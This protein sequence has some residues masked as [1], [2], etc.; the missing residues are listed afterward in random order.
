MKTAQRLLAASASLALFSTSVPSIAIAAN[1]NNPLYIQ[2]SQR[3]C[4]RLAGREKM[5]CLATQERGERLRLY[6]PTSTATQNAS[7]IRARRQIQ[8]NISSRNLR[9]RGATPNA[10]LLSKNLRENVRTRRQVREALRDARLGC[11]SIDDSTE[12]ALCYRKALSE[13]Q[14]SNFQ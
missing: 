6:L 8:A 14:Q 2:A 1:T 5:R 10:R 4:E 7:T 9:A 12:K 11:R 13:A 3:R